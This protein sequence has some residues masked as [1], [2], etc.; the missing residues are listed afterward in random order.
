[1]SEGNGSIAKER[2]REIANRR[3]RKE[4]EGAFCRSK[5]PEDDEEE[6]EVCSREKFVGM[7]R[8]LY[9]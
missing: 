5:R 1:M 9:K 7:G 3:M 8:R 2:E 6:E 4:K